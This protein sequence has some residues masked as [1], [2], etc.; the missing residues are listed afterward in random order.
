MRRFRHCFAI[1]VLLLTAL[2]L[3]VNLA[4]QATSQRLILKDGSY[5]VVRKYEV[6]GD[7]VRY[8]SAERG[9]WEEVPKDLIDWIATEKWAR[10]HAPGAEPPP[11]SSPGAVAAAEIDKEAEAEKAEA[12]ARMPEISKGLRLPDQEGVWALDT[13]HGGL[14]L[15][16]V[17][18]SSGDVSQATGHNVLKAAINPL[19][20]MKQSI[21]I[22]GPKSKVQLHVNDPAI[23]VSLDSNTPAEAEESAVTVDTHGAS[24]A[25]KNKDAHSSPDSRY[26]IVRL[27]VRKNLRV[28]GSLNVN[29]L[30]KVSQS[31]DMVD[32]ASETLPGKRWMKLTPKQPLDIGD[33][34]LVEV[35]SS[36]EIN[37]DVWDFR[38][39]PTAPDNPNSIMPL[40]R[41]P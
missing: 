32:T 27:Q 7:R 29:M 28:V 12:A 2:T 8:L 37:I 13:F 25:I 36:K 20:G 21:Q 19:G 6:V 22:E 16:R 3:P 9:D 15:V 17:N 30:G 18:Q 11:A 4:A 34:A 14:E 35:L 26:A 1:L 33:Y 39:D 41:E 38:I 5:Q 23:Y 31:E 40:Q 24:S 10:D